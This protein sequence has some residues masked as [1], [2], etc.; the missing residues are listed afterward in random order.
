MRA[1]AIATPGG[2]NWFDNFSSNPNSPLT[3]VRRQEPT[4]PSLAYDRGP[5]G[6]WMPVPTRDSAESSGDDDEAG[7][8]VA[9]RDSDEEEEAEERENGTG[10]SRHAADV[11]EENSVQRFNLT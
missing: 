4:F 11:R 1:A 2:D 5:P 6:P 8:L 7:R 3:G 9:V 10:R